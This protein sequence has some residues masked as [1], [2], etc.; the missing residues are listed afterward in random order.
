MV[1]QAQQQ[2]LENPPMLCNSGNNSG[3]G[4]SDNRGGGRAVDF[5]YSPQ[6]KQQQ[7][8]MAMMG[9]SALANQ[10]RGAMG[11]PCSPSSNKALPVD[12]SYSLAL[13]MDKQ[14]QEMDQ[15]LCLQTER[16]RVT[17]Q[18]QMKEHLVSLM[19]KLESKASS[20][21]RQKDEDLVRANKRA[22]ELEEYL[23]QAEAEGQ[24]WQRIARE[25]EAMALS[26]RSTL[27]QVGD[28]ACLST[29][30][31]AFAA[32]AICDAAASCCA[33]SSTPPGPNGGAK[34]EEGEQG[35]AE[36]GRCRGCGSQG[37]CMLFMPCMHLCAC[38][39][40]DTLLDSCPVCRCVK[41]GSIEVF[42]S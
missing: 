29:V 3:L 42:F 7:Q 41:H 1:V 12:V 40:C 9:R 14:N 26:L 20:L 34:Q 13:Q 24:T 27:E 30:G 31:G 37:S 17:L 2:F 15:Y 28:N 16:L 36:T 25:N 32:A 8:A 23:R 19:R 35:L 22:A 10:Q 6:Q 11:F 33:S 18:Q 38:K 5:Y 21:L 4:W 39:L